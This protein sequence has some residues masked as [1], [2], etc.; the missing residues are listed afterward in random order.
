[1]TRAK[2]R[3]RNLIGTGT[4]IRRRP[5]V[6]LIAIPA[7]SLIHIACRGTILFIDDEIEMGFMVSNLFTHHGYKIFTAETVD[8]ALEMSDNIPLDAIILDVEPGPRQRPQNHDFFWHRNH[9][10]IP[11]IIYTGRRMMTRW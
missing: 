7:D 8:V 6:Y 1:L 11:I 4:G 3:G 10:E 5:T 2:I 9:P